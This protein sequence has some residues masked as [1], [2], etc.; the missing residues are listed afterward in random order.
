M[1]PGHANPPHNLGADIEPC[2]KTAECVGQVGEEFT[3][4]RVWK[5]SIKDK[6]IAST[7][8]EDLDQAL[9]A[10][11]GHE[12]TDRDFYGFSFEDFVSVLV[13]MNEDP[14]TSAA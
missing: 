4:G 1:I 6:E 9:A 3:A 12:S 10:Q 14:D 13:A 11:S 2:P 8:T 5:T 7:K